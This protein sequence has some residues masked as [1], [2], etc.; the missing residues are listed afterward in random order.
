VEL[1]D[2]VR[3][4]VPRPGGRH[5]ADAVL[6]VDARFRAPERVVLKLLDPSTRV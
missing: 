1:A 2:P 3:R 6:L 4:R 5:R